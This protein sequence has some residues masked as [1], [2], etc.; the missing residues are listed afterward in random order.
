MQ[1]LEARS[2]E[3]SIQPES[4]IDPLI[5]SHK[6]DIVAFTLYLLISQLYITRGFTLQQIQTVWQQLKIFIEK[7]EKKVSKEEVVTRI[8]DLLETN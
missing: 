6:K 2:R 5:D 1:P 7:Q 3:K 4:L 8:F